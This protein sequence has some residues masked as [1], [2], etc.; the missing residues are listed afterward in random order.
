ML[1]LLSACEGGIISE[2][3]TAEKAPG[4]ARV[5]RTISAISADQIYQ[6]HSDVFG[7]PLVIT[8]SLGMA[9]AISSLVWN[10]QEYI[11]AAD[12]GRELQSAVVYD[13][14]G[15]CLNP[16]EAGSSRDRGNRTTSQLMGIRAV[17]NQLST[18]T[19]MAYWTPAGAAYP[20]GCGP[21][22]GQFHA[23][24]TTDVS[25]DIHSKQVTIGYSGLENVIE[26][27]VTYQTAQHHTGAAFEALTGYMTADFSLFWTFDPARN[28]L[29]Q[30]SYDHGEQNKPVILSTP[31]KNHAMGIYSPDLPEGNLG[32]GRFAFPGNTMKW[33]A[34]FRT[35]DTPPGNYNFRMYVS[36]GSLEQVKASM[37]AL[38]LMFN[39]NTDPGPGPG[40]TGPSGTQPIYRYFN[41]ANGLHFTSGL[42]AEAGAPWLLEGIL[43]SIFTNDSESRHLIYRCYVATGDH[44]VSTD[45]NCEKQGREAPM[46]YVENQPTVNATRPLL[47]CYNL[48]IGHMESTSDMECSAN[49]YSVEQTL[50]YVP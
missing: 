46:G 37:R 19:R 47:R 15:E 17:G 10:G 13:G 14:Y 8:T 4:V 49:G 20:D 6:I 23:Q 5:P 21:P 3:R 12:H 30:L 25:D 7:S 32:Y 48:L 39:P 38:H 26:Y 11:N 50:G 28:V 35:G 36:V 22:P 45:S 34:V 31:A 43:Y 9:G 18:T 1:A 16:T 40:T 41:S 24:N 42:S 2:P 33:N 29:D 44:F 27:L